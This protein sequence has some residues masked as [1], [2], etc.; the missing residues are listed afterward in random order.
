MAQEINKFALLV[1]TKQT[2]DK[3]LYSSLKVFCENNPQ[4]S[5]NT[6]YNYTS[7]KKTPFEDDLIMIEKIPY[8]KPNP[9]KNAIKKT[10]SK[11]RRT[12]DR[13]RRSRKSLPDSISK[14]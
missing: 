2:Q 12:D 14:R 8:F 4:Y 5:I 7:R 3:V 6:I 10:A 9:K 13:S 1:T 11:V